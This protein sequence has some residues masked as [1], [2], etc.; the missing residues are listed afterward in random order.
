MPLCLAASCD[1]MACDRM[2]EQMRNLEQENQVLRKQALEAASSAQV[3]PGH[4]WPHASM[5]AAAAAHAAT[6]SQPLVTPPTT[7][8]LTGSPGPSPPTG[9]TA[10][11]AST[12]AP[13]ALAKVLAAS[14]QLG[15][16]P[17]A[18]HPPAMLVAP[19]TAPP[20]SGAVAAASPTVPSPLPSDATQ[21]RMRQILDKQAV[22][23]SCLRSR[24]A[25]LHACASQA[26]VGLVLV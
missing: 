20:A 6:A 11:D 4:V 14:P 15:P 9:D 21:R 13:L 7:L 12:P 1:G 2:E 10:S 17:A 18:A 3:P 22:R 16:T 24:P 5:A 8:R 23:C 25:W 26:G 19:A